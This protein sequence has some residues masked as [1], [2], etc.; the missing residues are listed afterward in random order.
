MSPETWHKSMLTYTNDPIDWNKPS[1][2]GQCNLFRS[3]VAK[4]PDK[5]IGLIDI[6]LDDDKVLLDYPQAGMR[7]LLDAGRVDN[8]LHVL[9]HILEVIGNDVNSTIRGFSLHSLLF[10]LNEMPKMDQVPELVF[11][12]FCNA[13]INAKESVEDR[14]KDDKDVQTVGINQPRGNAGYMLVE[15]A[16]NYQYKEEIFSTIE[17]IAESASVYTRAA[18]LLNMA[19]L[20]HL[21]KKRNVELFKKL[22]HD[23]NPRLMAL[24]VHNY[25]PLV[26]FV[27]YAVDDLIDFFNHAVESP[28][29]YIEQIIIS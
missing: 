7:G 3:V 2:T 16:R 9:E 17:Q 25:N 26:Y 19:A 13:L 23:F 20:N 14:H 4:E 12:L 10:A 28:E 11:N 29:C 1:L 8:A 6:V 27:N 18:V 22:M 24:P 21:D 15:C 5:Y